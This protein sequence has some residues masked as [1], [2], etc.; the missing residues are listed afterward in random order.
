[1]GEFNQSKYIADYIKQNYDTIKFQ[2][3]KGY[4]DKV[5]KLANDN[6]CKSMNE[7]IRQLIDKQLD[8]Q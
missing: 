1:M 3:P 7:Y 4:K 8:K 5:K 6:G 2:L